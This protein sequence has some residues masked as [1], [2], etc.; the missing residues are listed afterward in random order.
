MI[1]DHNIQEIV[2]IADR[3]Y[4]MFNGKIMKYGS[5]I[6]ILQDPLIRKIYLGNR[7]INLKKNESS[8]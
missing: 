2:T 1:T 8:I 6:E 4:L 5:T 7:I 3:I